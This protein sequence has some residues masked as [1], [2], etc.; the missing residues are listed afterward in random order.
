MFSLQSQSCPGPEGSTT[1]YPWGKDG[2]SI[3]GTR[4]EWV[5]SAGSRDG[6]GC[7]GNVLCSWDFHRHLPALAPSRS[8]GEQG[9]SLELCARDSGASGGWGTAWLVGSRGFFPPSLVLPPGMFLR[10]VSPG[11]GEVEEGWEGDQAVRSLPPSGRDWLKTPSMVS[12]ELP[13]PPHTRHLSSLE[14]EPSTRSQPT[15]CGR[16]Q[17]E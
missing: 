5:C 4:M 6:T 14:S 10:D 12:Q 3:W 7:T 9:R 1:P 11:A 17:Q 13:S 15:C 2:K 8:W 16:E